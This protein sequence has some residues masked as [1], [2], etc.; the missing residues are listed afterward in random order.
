[1]SRAARVISTLW[2]ASTLF[3]CGRQQVEPK[4]CTQSRQQAHESLRTGKVEAAKAQLLI[5]AASCSKASAWDVTRMQELLTLQEAQRRLQ[6]EHQQKERQLNQKQPVR[7]FLLWARRVLA[8]DKER[9]GKASCAPRGAPDFGFCTTRVEREAGETG[10]PFSVRYV[11]SNPKLFRLESE[12][13]IPVACDDF[14]P[15]RPGPARTGANGDTLLLCELTEHPLTGLTAF[16]RIS[17]GRSTVVLFPDR[18]RDADPE[19]NKL[20]GNNL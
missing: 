20:V 3:G 6:L 16:I 12:L 17:S 15:N 19:F 4:A 10:A 5:A 9:L 14:G 8:A 7:P 2:F 13:P 11:A 1:V 18:Y